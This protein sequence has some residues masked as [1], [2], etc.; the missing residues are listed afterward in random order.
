LLLY[1][2]LVFQVDDD[3]PDNG[4]PMS[5]IKTKFAAKVSEKSCFKKETDDEIEPPDNHSPSYES[6]PT[7]YES[8]PIGTAVK[9]PMKLCFKEEKDDEIELP[10]TRSP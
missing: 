9:V 10:D 6:K 8:K 4:S 3:K 2:T 5:A 7:S 1:N